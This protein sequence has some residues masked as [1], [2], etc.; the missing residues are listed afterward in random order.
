MKIPVR[1]VSYR[2]FDEHSQDGENL[3]KRQIRG[4]LDVRGGVF[5]GLE[6]PAGAFPNLGKYG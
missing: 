2:K 3:A 4:K 1:W 5:Q 6:N